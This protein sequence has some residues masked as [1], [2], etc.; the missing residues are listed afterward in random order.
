MNSMALRWFSLSELNKITPNRATTRPLYLKSCKARGYKARIEELAN[1][2]SALYYGADPAVADKVFVYLHGGGFYVGA[3]PGHWVFFDSLIAEAEKHGKVLSVVLLEYTLAPS[4]QC[5]FQIT[6]TITFFQH[7][8]QTIPPSKIL[9]S[10]ESAGGNLSLA[11]LAHILHPSPYGPSIA[12]ES[13]LAGVLLISPWVAPGTDTESMTKF[14]DH[15]ILF[16]GVVQALMEEYNPKLKIRNGWTE[17]LGA[18][19]GWWKGCGALL[20]GKILIT[21]G[22]QEL[23]RD[24]IVAL[25]KRFVE[26]EVDVEV[27]LP[28]G[29]H[30]EPIHG[31][32]SLGPEGSGAWLAHLRWI[33]EVVSK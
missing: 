30:A 28:D 10:G 29:T 2:T 13:P 8:L 22:A 23:M 33:G 1:N 12:L 6:Q 19:K 11:L 7:L 15:D 16:P 32:T 9:L 21:G 3:V 27:F 18:E 14:A 26:E 31:L 24:D 5:P 4:K 17:A 25:G 20:E